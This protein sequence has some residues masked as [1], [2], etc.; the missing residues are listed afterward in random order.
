M[1]FRLPVAA[2]ALTLLASA[3]AADDVTT[4]AGKKL[5]GKLVAVDAQ[6]IAFSTGEAKVTIPARDIVLVDFGNKPVAVPK[7]VTYSEIELTDGSVFRAAKF[8]LKGKVMTTELLPGGPTPP[9]AY[10][11]PMGAVFSA[12]K[13]ADDPKARD[14]WKKLLAGRGKRDMYVMQ[15]ETGLTYQ[16]GTI[17]S[18]SAD[19]TTLSFESESGGKG[20]DLRQS[21]A[22]GL[23]FYQPQQASVPPTVCRVVDVYGN[24]LNAAAVAIAPDGVSV[25]TVAGAVVKYPSVAALVR[26]DYESGNLAYL[27]DLQPLVD[28]PN[29]KPE[30]AKLEP[31][32][33]DGK[34]KDQTT[35]NTPLK[36]DGVL[37]AKGVCVI[38]ETALTYN[39]NGDFA[40]F[41]AVAGIDENGMSALPA[42][43]LIIEADG[44]VVFNEV[45]RRK[46]KPKGVTLAVKGVKQLRLIVEVDTP[47]VNGE[48]VALAEARVQK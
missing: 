3:A 5:S 8:A 19:G 7:D 13:R 33:A 31:R 18:G 34:L 2:L 12:M 24:T 1:R 9:P 16:Q 14:A 15:Q 22:A 41:K 20:T 21:R 37:Y 26:F 35:A 36:L 48:Y 10:E 47:P 11:L 4:T 38:P 17:L 46:D 42:A 23:V 44:Q 43:R 30:D 40:Q 28:A 39:L 6:G 27:S 32:P 25:T 45:L 29:E